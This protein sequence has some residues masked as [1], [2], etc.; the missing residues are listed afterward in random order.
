MTLKIVYGTIVLCAVWSTIA[1]AEQSK[2]IDLNEENW[3]SILD[4]EW[5]IEFYAPWCP[6]CK[7]LAPAWRKL[8]EW[9]NDIDIRTAQIDVTTSPALS[10][11]FLVAALPTIFHVINGE[12]RQYRGPGDADSFI[13]FIEERKW[14]DIDPV[15]AWKHPD[16]VQMTIMSYFFKLSHYLKEVNNV[17]LIDYGMPPWLTYVLFAIV[18]I[19]LG[20]LLGLILVSIIDLIFPSQSSRQSFAQGQAPSTDEDAR[21]VIEDDDATSAAV[22][23][24][25][26]DDDDDEEEDEAPSTS[27]GEKFSG[28]ESDASNEDDK[29]V[30]QTDVKKSPNSEPEVRKRKPRKAD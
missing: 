4:K 1:L 12:F 23:A 29:D 26:D 19:L 9:S 7:N 28:S 3:R 2:V 6:A 17:M 21:D 10:G 27:E 11:R 14:K 18:T 20:A 24:N 16:S 5:M 25:D 8:G 15:S 22:A 13:T 30:Q